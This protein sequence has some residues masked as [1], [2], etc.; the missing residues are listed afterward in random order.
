M[1]CKTQLDKNLS[2]CEDWKAN[3]RKYCKCFKKTKKCFSKYFKV[4]QVGK[5]VQVENP[6]MMI[7]ESSKMVGQDD[8]GSKGEKKERRGY[9]WSVAGTLS[10]SIERWRPFIATR[11]CA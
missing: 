4:L 10:L 5:V 7:R 1:Q 9:P 6:K 8:E 3:E 2:T 11:K